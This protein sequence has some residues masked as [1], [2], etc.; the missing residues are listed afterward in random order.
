M[1]QINF[2]RRGLD[3]VVGTPGRIIDLINRGALVL[4]EV[5]FIVL[6][7]ADQMLNVGFDEDVEVIME[8]LP[9]KCQS[10]LFSATMPVWVQRLSRKYLNDPIVIDLVGE[11]SQKLADGISLYSIAASTYGKCSIINPLIT[12]YAKG[13]KCIVFTQTK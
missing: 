6:D 11:S 5:Q 1:S 3:I 13:G 2:L 10:M 9:K 4:S 7:E 12:E 8:R